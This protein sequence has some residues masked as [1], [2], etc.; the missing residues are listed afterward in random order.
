MLPDGRTAF[1]LIQNATDTGQGSLVFFLFD[2]LHLDG[3]DLTGLPVI[4]R[5]DRLRALLTGAPASL[6]LNA[7][8]IFF[9]NYSAGLLTRNFNTYGLFLHAYIGN[10]F[11][12]GYVFE[13]PTGK[14]VGANYTTHEI[15]LGFRLNVLNFHDNKSI[16]SF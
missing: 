11:R 6:D 5:K 3:E 14:S 15:T 8:L 2:L 7:S 13:V 9:E 12:V 1:N 16:M 10:S 4:D